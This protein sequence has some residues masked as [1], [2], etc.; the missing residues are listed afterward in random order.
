MKGELN[1]L[2]KEFKL[3]E[4]KKIIFLIPAVI[5]VLAIVMGIIFGVRNGSP[6]NLG[7]D[8]TGGYI[9]KVE[10]GTKLTEDT[11][12]YYENRVR[13]IMGD[14]VYTADDG[15]EYK[16]TIDSVRVT[17]EGDETSLQVRYQSV[18]GSDDVI[19]EELNKL[20]EEAVNTQLTKIIPIGVVVNG[21][22]VEATYNEPVKSYLDDGGI[23]KGMLE[24]AGVSYSDIKGEALDNGNYKVVISGVTG[25]NLGVEHLTEAL[26]IDD[27]GAGQAGL[28]GFTGAAISSDLIYNAIT[29]VIIALVVM[30]IY[31]AIVFEFS[32]GLSA[33]IALLHDIM[34]MF[35]GMVIF[36]IELSSTFIAALVTILGYSINNSIIVFDRVRE[37]RRNMYNVDKNVTAAR[38]ANESVKSSLL[39]C[40]NT[41]ITTLIMIGMVAI[42]CGIGGISDM[43]NFALPIIFGLVAGVF[44][45]TCIAPSIWTLMHKNGL[46]NIRQKKERKPVQTPVQTDTVPKEAA[47]S[48]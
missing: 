41:T 30:L 39:R 42:V 26:T 14:V 17:G 27:S 4:K 31:I 7:M 20:L 46:G 15:K 3:V 35:A 10:L 16:V 29:A 11:T 5:L 8:F 1:V 38:V 21:S 36:Q 19:M 37:N 48:E 9:F 45:A 23:L 24:K 12:E 43:V 13:D 22:V 33:I 47:L 44:S 18:E 40:I 28:D 2:E 6:F 32:S 25:Q 34:I